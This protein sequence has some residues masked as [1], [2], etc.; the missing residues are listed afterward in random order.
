M[1][2]LNHL[3][4]AAFKLNSVDGGLNHSTRFALVD[5]RR[6]V[7]GYYLSSDESFPKNLLHDLT[8]LQHERP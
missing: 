3:G 4:L 8:V 1:P 2:R 7:R 6:R 5:G